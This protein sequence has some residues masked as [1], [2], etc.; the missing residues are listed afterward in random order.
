M[1]TVPA[2]GLM[3]PDSNTVTARDIRAGLAGRA[4]LLVET[5][6]LPEPVTSEGEL[7]MLTTEAPEAARRLGRRAPDV[8]VFGCSSA[9]SVLGSVAAADELFRTLADLA[10]SPVIGVNSCLFDALAATGA[11]RITLVSPYERPLHEAVAAQLAAAGFTVLGGGNMGIAQNALVGEV[12]PDEVA[13]FA[14]ECI[15]P[16]S[17]A[18][19]VACGNLRADEARA[20]IAAQ[21]GIPVVTAN[22]AVVDAVLHWLAN[23]PS[24]DPF[25]DPGTVARYGWTPML[26][27]SI[28]TSVERRL[29]DLPNHVAEKAGLCILDALACAAGGRDF[30][31][32]AAARRVVPEGRPA[33]AATVWSD[34]SEVAVPDAV[35][36]NSVMAHSIVQEDMHPASRSHIGTMV[37]PVALALAEELG[38]S[39]REV[40][41]AVVAGYEV[42]ARVGELLTTADFVARGLRPSSVFGPFGSAMA[43]A[44]LL[45]LGHDTTVAALGLAGSSAS[46]TC[47][48][49]YGGTPDVYF[50]NGAAA[51]AG[52]VAARLAALG[53]AG[54]A[55]VLEGRSGLL[56]ALAGVPHGTVRATPEPAGWA[57]SEVYF[58]AYP[59]CAFTQEAIEAARRLV[60][61]GLR[62]SDVDRVEI[63]TYGMGKRYPGCDN[64]SSLTTTLERQMSNQFAVATMLVD[65]ELTLD[66][67]LEPLSP[68]IAELAARIRVREDPELEA[69]YPAVPSVRLLVTTRTGGRREASVRGGAYL[70]P[71]GVEE[72]F[73]RYVAGR[74]DPAGADA[75]VSAVR[76]LDGAVSIADVLKP[77]RA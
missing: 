21:A 11:A 33:V 46:G 15:G 16:G 25:A 53:V 42:V 48:W 19:L 28:V 29:P 26:T 35:Y 1:S 70:G 27:D 31:W 57:I 23:S 61:A 17:E 4:E 66:R 62:V 59:S 67:F 2:V 37:V 45:G 20:A 56:E 38:S 6:H 74:L 36:V 55:D 49:A 8:T 41:E 75:V 47:V 18:V 43:A 54:S 63:A 22:S 10:G 50:Q 51:R 30:A 5:M 3:L 64:G 34:G 14:L 65:G 9:V 60:A 39:G 68:A 69:A 77:Y 58:K 24:P 52:V 13:R 71:D 7:G 44:R 32:S 40:V 76:S 12:T 73:R 72:K